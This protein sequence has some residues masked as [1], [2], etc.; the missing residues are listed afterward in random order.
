V[1]MEEA[2]AA[3]SRA[4]AS[5]SEELEQAR[6][7][8]ADAQEERELARGGVA[9]ARREAGEILAEARRAADDLLARA[10]REVAEVRRELTRQRNVRGGRGQ[11]QPTAAALEKLASRAEGSRAAAAAGAPPVADET[12]VAQPRVGLWGRSRTLGSIGRIVDVSGRTG[13]VTLETDGP[14]VVIPGDDV[15]VIPEPVATPAPR[16][17]E[18]DELR[19]RAASR[20]S[21]QLDLR[22]ERVEAALE[23]LSAYL[24]EALLAGLD[25]AV[26]LHGSGTG[27]L[28]R[29]VRERLAEH[30]RVQRVRSGRREEGG[31]QA[32]VAEL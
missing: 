28:R 25:Q 11:A 17:A 31:D 21:P 7:E 13:R 15:E 23:Q 16:D 5:R 27:A 8:R 2:L 3:I 12:D 18:S 10:E 14:R 20:I 24:D 19:R 30:P 22:G 26:I 9:R 1:T 32:T 4:E 29:A 6:R